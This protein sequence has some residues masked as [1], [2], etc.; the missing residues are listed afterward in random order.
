MDMEGVKVSRIRKNADVIWSH[1]CNRCFWCMDDIRGSTRLSD[2]EIYLALGWLARQGDVS[3]VKI[4][5]KVRVVL[6][7]NVYW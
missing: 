5:D 6:A 1:L 4:D 2:A 7:A 3:F